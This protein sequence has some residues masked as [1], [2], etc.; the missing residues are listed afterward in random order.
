MTKIVDSRLIA[1]LKKVMA[2][3]DARCRHTITDM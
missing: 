1:D 2:S 3:V